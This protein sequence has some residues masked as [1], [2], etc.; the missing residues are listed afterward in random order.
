MNK[1]DTSPSE[2]DFVSLLAFVQTGKVVEAIAIVEA[3]P[4]P[5]EASVAFIELSKQTYRELQDISSMVALG[6]AGTQFALSK[7]ASSENSADVP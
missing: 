3:I 5:M 4:N 2:A 1:E 6:H 7:A